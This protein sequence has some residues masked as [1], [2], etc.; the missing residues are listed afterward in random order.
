VLAAL[1]QIYANVPGA[2]EDRDPEFL[3]QL[4]VGL[5][6]LRSTLRAFRSALRKR[7]AAEIDATLREILQAFGEAR[8]WDVFFRACGDSRLQQA[9]RRR[10]QPAARRARQMLRSAGFRAALQRVLDWSKGM[11]WRRGADPDA[12]MAPFAGHSLQRLETRMR[13][14]AVDADWRDAA[15][16]HRVRVK[17]KRL[18]YGCE[19]FSAAYQRHKMLPYLK[20][21]RR[22]QKVLGELNDIA[23]QRPLLRALARTAQL[24]QSAATLAAALE[25]REEELIVEAAQAW[26]AL[27][28]TKP[29]WRRPSAVR[30]GG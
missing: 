20:R 13:G 18:R 22:V 23:V 28:L 2:S 29:F 11:P 26:G 6:R 12:P 17:L 9:A 7:E 14:E 27:D 1:E 5:R 21:L 30:A 19:C 25:V 15:R 24:R 16:R 4:R 10:R 8:D 3:H